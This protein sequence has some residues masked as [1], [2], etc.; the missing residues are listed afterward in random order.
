MRLVIKPSDLF[1]KIDI[2]ASKSHTIRA[3]FI[4]SLAEG[5]SEIIKPLDSLDTQAAVHCAEAFGAT[6]KQGE[7]WFI[8]GV[9][10]HPK[11]PDDVVY[12]GNSGS[13]ANFFMG[14]AATV[15]GYTVLS[16]DAQ[17]R[18]RPV[19]PLIDELNNLGATVFSTRDNGFPPV[20]IRGKLKGGQTKVEGKTSIYT[21]A[22]L[23]NCPMA[24]GDTELIVENPKE[25]PY[26]E[27]TL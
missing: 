23:M 26:V 20:V 24:D 11:V 15:D 4:G 19:Q 6:V 9:G 27:M 5:S 21:S 12:V 2:P 22:L 13:A 1:G 3:V 10:G 8:E 16:G 18:R 7:N 14:L 25:K 17:I